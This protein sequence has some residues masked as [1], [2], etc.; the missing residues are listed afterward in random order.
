M[1]IMFLLV[2]GNHVVPNLPFRG[3]LVLEVKVDGILENLFLVILGEPLLEQTRLVVP[4]PRDSDGNVP[5]VRA[6][7]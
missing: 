3:I 1:A 4:V 2:H 6:G 7:R 5:V